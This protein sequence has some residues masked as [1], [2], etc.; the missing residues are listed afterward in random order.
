MRTVIVLK[1]VKNSDSLKGK[2]NSVSS[3]PELRQHTLQQRGL[4]VVSAYVVPHDSAGK[5]NRTKKNKK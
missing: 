1:F 3:L 2:K 5:K 4:G